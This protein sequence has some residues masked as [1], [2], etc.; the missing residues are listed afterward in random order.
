MNAI[1]L[2]RGLLRHPAPVNYISID[3]RADDSVRLP[4]GR[5]GTVLEFSEDGA[6]VWIDFGLYQRWV[7]LQEVTK[8]ER[9]W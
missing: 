2:L 8:I 4:D 6:W 1:G 5:L 3:I 7:D 9:S